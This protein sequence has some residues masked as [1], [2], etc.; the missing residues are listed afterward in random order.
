MLVEAKTG[1]VLDFQV[2]TGASEKSERDVS[3]GHKVV[4]QLMEPYQGKGHRLLLTTSTRVLL[5]FFNY[6]K[7]GHIVLALCAQIERTFRMR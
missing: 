7:W 4:M 3:L 6:L 5:S 2:Y 1:Y